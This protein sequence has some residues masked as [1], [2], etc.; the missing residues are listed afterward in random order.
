[1]TTDENKVHTAEGREFHALVK[2]KT[3]WLE[4]GD[5]RR[6]VAA[7]EGQPDN[8][9]VTFWGKRDSMLVEEYHVTTAHVRHTDW[10]ASP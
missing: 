3:F 6:L 4:L 9:S 5:L 1:M 10:Q 2:A 7:A 8:A